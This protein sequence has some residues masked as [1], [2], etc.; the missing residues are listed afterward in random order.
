MW[1]SAASVCS[2]SCLPR[3]F[4]FSPFSF[5][6]FTEACGASLLLVTSFVV[7]SAPFSSS[8]ELYPLFD[9]S[10]SSS[11][12]LSAICCYPHYTKH[13]HLHTFSPKKNNVAATSVEHML[14]LL[15]LSFFAH[16]FILQ[17]KKIFDLQLCFSINK[18]SEL[19]CNKKSS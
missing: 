1:P 19:Y 5:R 2:L 9:A 7:F 3:L 6:A 8:K 17:N 18:V 13:T 4:S 16:P 14:S 12:K 15:F 11:C 10:E